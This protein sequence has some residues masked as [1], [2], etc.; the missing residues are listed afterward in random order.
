MKD[1][2]MD[3]KN[4]SA[5]EPTICRDC[6]VTTANDALYAQVDEK[7]NTLYLF[8]LCDRCDVQLEADDFGVPLA[9]YLA[10]VPV[11][12]ATDLGKGIISQ[13]EAEGI[14]KRY[15]PFAIAA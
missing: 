6:G 5:Q 7:G 4:T 2:T 13:A 12:I 9:D 8:A 11:M 3:T 15:A 1:E 10:L 14:H